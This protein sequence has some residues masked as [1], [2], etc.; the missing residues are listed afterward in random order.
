MIST[1]LDK[2]L[3]TK[4][5]FMAGGEKRVVEV[6]RHFIRFGHEVTVLTTK[7]SCLAFEKER[8]KIKTIIVRSL[9]EK[10][11]F[12][13]ISVVLNYLHRSLS[14][15]QVRKKSKG[16]FD[17]ILVATAL[18]PD[19]LAC[20][21]L[22]SKYRKAKGFIYLHHVFNII[23]PTLKTD[24]FKKMRLF[25]FTSLSVL[26]QRLVIKLIKKYKIAVFALPITTIMLSKMLDKERIRK[27]ENG[28]NLELARKARP[29]YSFE[30]IYIGRLSA[31][32]GA[33]DL[34]DIWRRVCDRYKYAKLA[35]VGSIEDPLVF[36]KMKA[37]NLDR[38][39]TFYEAVD[40]T[41]KFELMKSAKVFLFP[42]YEEGWGI[43]VSEALAC[44]I[45]VVVYDL[46]AYSYAGNSIIKVMKGNTVAFAGEVIQLLSDEKARL[47]LSV[48]AH[49]KVKDWGDIARDEIAMI[50]HELVVG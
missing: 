40:E 38:N 13:N 1:V 27:V 49:K 31:K 9:I 43:A 47:S 26:Q 12:G 8:L 29:I 33:Y 23:H 7:D 37:V 39:I 10:T 50:T 4:F 28:V 35:I 20:L 21:L 5:M 46:P 6:L 36:K 41:K 2:R 24:L 17:A 3:N 19:V 25:L 15:F 42:S 14:M 22:L 48:E 11:Q 16:N 34:I 44:E 45:P 18:L 30:G 32:K